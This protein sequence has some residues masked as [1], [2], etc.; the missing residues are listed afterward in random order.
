MVQLAK[1]IKTDGETAQISVER[2]SMCDGCSKK[3]CSGTCAA[4]RLF[5]TD[6]SMHALARNTIGADVGDTVQIETK[7]SVVMKYAL[8]IF[9]MPIIISAI[10][11]F[12]GKAV[13][14]EEKSAIAAA[15]IGF[16]A[17]FAVIGLIERR[18]SKSPPDVVIKRIIC[19]DSEEE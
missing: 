7:T 18:K 9:I 16:I 10:L 8:I 11:Y 3:G 5:G 6:K 15:F 1:V 13:F 17:S 2:S 4:G 19:P 12:I 14:H